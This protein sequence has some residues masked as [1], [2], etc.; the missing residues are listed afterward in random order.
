MDNITDSPLPAVRR[1]R[2][3]HEACGLKRDLGS[4][5]VYIAGG[6]LLRTQW[7]NGTSALP[8]TLIDLRGVPELTGIARGE[9]GLA[10]G[11]LTT[12]SACR[13]SGLLAEAAPAVK[14]AAR[15]IAAPS[16]RNLGTAGGNIASGTG[17]LLPALLAASAEV[18]LFDGTFRSRLGLEGWLDGRAE[19][20]HRPEQLLT[21]VILPPAAKAAGERRFQWFRKVGRRETFTPSLVTA[22]AAGTI[23]AD[24]RLEGVRIAAGGGS[25]RPHRLKEAEALLEGA[26]FSE[27]LL[28]PLYDAARSGFRTYADPFA[29]EDY[30]KKTA[31]NLIA[32][33]LWQEL[34]S[35]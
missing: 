33:G 17:D 21:G 23:L 4:A 28:A 35:G 1:P 5:A 8:A 16:V 26:V 18:E 14:E 31:A 25:G 7:E 20:A 10:I 2:S 6:T 12:L 3:L 29:S 11:A 24:G 27:A 30:K 9:Y 13:V 34:G 15:C 22:A 32:A 19:G